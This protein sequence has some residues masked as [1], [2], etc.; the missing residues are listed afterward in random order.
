MKLKVFYG[1]VL[2]VIFATGCFVPRSK[3]IKV[4][5]P[6]VNQISEAYVMSYN[7]E[8]LFDTINDPENDDDFTPNGKLNWNTKRYQEKLNHIAQV[9]EAVK[10]ENGN[11]WPMVIGLIEVEHASCLNDLVTKTLLNEG[12]YQVAFLEGEDE[13][14]IDVGL[15]FRSDVMEVVSVNK[16]NIVLPE[17]DKTRHILE[18]VGRVNNELVVFYVNHW[19]SR[20]GGTEKSAPSR[21][22]ASEQLSMVMTNRMKQMPDCNMILMGDFN[23]YPDNQ[24]VA[25]LEW[26]NGKQFSNLMKKT[27]DTNK[28]SHFYKGEWGF[29]DQFIVNSEILAQDGK[30]WLFKRSEAVAFDFMMYTNNKGEMSPSR[31]YVGDSYKGGYSDHLPILLELSYQK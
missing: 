14:G 19:P 15:L 4:G 31:T 6:R 20:S 22:L 3:R 16:H 23:D 12:H 30:G 5:M 26:V 29:L 21:Q 8:N 17:N 28:G 11:Q 25:R 18:V 10:N 1:L 9:V 27:D 24:S 13:R 2:M 7:V